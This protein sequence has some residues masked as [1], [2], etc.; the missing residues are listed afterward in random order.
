VCLPKFENIVLG[1][2]ERKVLLIRIAGA[3]LAHV[4]LISHWRTNSAR[5]EFGKLGMAGRFWKARIA[6]GDYLSTQALTAIWILNARDAAP[7]ID[8]LENGCDQGF[9]RVGRVPFWR[10]GMLD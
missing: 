10:I 4:D 6:A 9:N 1:V 7:K 3:W 5:S 8:F 2:D